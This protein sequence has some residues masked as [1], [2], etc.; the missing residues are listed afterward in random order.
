MIA[1]PRVS[2]QTTAEFTVY[3][4]AN[5]RKMRIAKQA[6]NHC[7]RRKVRCDISATG[8][9][10]SPCSNCRLKK[11]ADCKVHIKRKTLSS[12]A[13]A[14]STSSTSTLPPAL[15]LLRPKRAIDKEKPSYIHPIYT[16]SHD[17]PAHESGNIA[18]FL[19]K[20]TIRTANLDHKSRV[21][22]IG[23]EPSNFQYLVRQSSHLLDRDARIHHFSNRQYHPRHTS[24]RLDSLPADSF[25][26]PPPALERELLDAYFT[27][28]NCGWP[29]IDEEHFRIQV[30]GEDA[31]DPV[32]LPLLNAVLLVGAHV[33]V[34]E[35]PEL[36]HHQADFFR[37]A[38]SLMD[39][40]SEQDRLIYVQSALLL[41]WYADGL[42]EVIAN[43]WYWIGFA[44][45]T[46]IG[47]GMHRDPTHA[48]HPP[49]QRRSWI[50][51]WWM[52]F[53]FD[54]LMALAYGRPQAMYVSSL[55]PMSVHFALFSANTHI[56]T[57]TSTTATCR[58]SHS[59][60]S[61]A[62][63]MPRPTSSLPTRASASSSPKSCAIAGPSAQ[64]QPSTTPAGLWISSSPTL[65]AI[66][67]PPWAL[68]R[69]SQRPRRAPTA[70]PRGEQSCISTTARS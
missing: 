38:K 49:L 1:T 16:E 22:Y 55:L 10:S 17:D 9:G 62:S 18:D 48:K 32:S 68:L 3:I 12:S 24:Y 6:C 7:H 19:G 47:I 13:A 44:A 64:L 15:P 35:K 29:I 27:H 69:S 61:K 43:S 54:A 14:A 25:A 52:L 2:S 33:L 65:Q 4:N 23:N 41:T 58:K 34:R 56:F 46:A 28:I 60:I 40:R 45:R 70:A 57:A 31:R 37:R 53:Q 63:P 39:A 21:C 20:E 11:I 36:K 8:G 66:C 59:A 67:R 26:R 42:E 30:S 50:R 5:G 51:T